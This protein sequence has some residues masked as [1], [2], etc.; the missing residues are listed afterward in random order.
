MAAVLHEHASAAERDHDQA[1]AEDLLKRL[2][3]YDDGSRTG[4]WTAK[5]TLSLSTSP[6]EATRTIARYS[7]GP[8]GART[9]GEASALDPAAKEYI[10]IPGS[11]LLVVEAPGR[12]TVRYPL[13][14]TRGEELAVHLNLLAGPLV[15]E[16]FVHVP[17]GRFWF[18]TAAFEEMRAWQ[19]AV[20]AHLRETGAFL[21]ARE[22][23]TFGQWIA[24]V[25]ALP[26]ERRELF[27]PQVMSGHSG[28]L[29]LSPSGGGWE[30]RLQP[31]QHTY[32]VR[33]GEPLRYLDRE[34]AAAEMDWLRL[35]VSGVS[36]EQASAYVAWL[37]ETGKVPLARMC[38][39]DEWERAARGADLRIYPH[40]D[41]LRPEDANFDETYG[42]RERAFGPDEVGRHP[43]VRSPFGLDDMAGNVLELAAS[44]RAEG[45]VVLRG[46]AYY[47]DRTSSQVTNRNAF[48]R[49]DRLPT[50][51]FRVC[52]D[53][54][55]GLAAGR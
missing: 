31:N 53:V 15:P 1:R 55:G 49:G 43:A 9:L 21:I 34:G 22:E 41:A 28:T 39:E 40:G 2:A 10:L 26:A 30:L 12:A 45:A 46:G 8:D 38:R 18:G 29:L 52:A 51:G 14:L 48:S 36:W 11:Y 54:P 23:T 25:E 4:Q 6:E 50:V 37:S 3:V 32:V 35:P 24:F 5:A 13:E 27:L 19:S 20:P 33:T 7:M 42:R 16:G 17:A 44:V 47:F